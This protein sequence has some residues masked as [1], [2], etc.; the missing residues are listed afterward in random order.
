MVAFDRYLY[1]FG[2]VADNTLPSDLYRYVMLYGRLHGATTNQLNQVAQNPIS[3][4][5]VGGDSMEFQ[6]SSLLLN[7]FFLT[8]CVVS[9]RS[10]HGTFS[11]T[12]ELSREINGYFL[13]YESAGLTFCHTVSFLL[14]TFLKKFFV[15]KISL[16]C[17][18]RNVNL[19]C[20]GDFYVW[21]QN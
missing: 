11:L 2:G 3:L 19:S 1:V 13:L 17:I 14:K 10:E 7:F 16:H 6:C 5:Q 8:S 15:I 9:T 12:S 4:N 20:H 18:A 21:G